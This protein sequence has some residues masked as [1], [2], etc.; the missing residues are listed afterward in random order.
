VVT[1]LRPMLRLAKLEGDAAFAYAMTDAVDGPLLQD[2]IEGSYFAF[3]RRLRDIRQSSSCECNACIL[4]PALD[5]KYVLHHG[6]VVRQ[7]I[8]SSEELVGSDVIV[9]HR[10]LKNG[11]TE[12]T[13]IGAYALYTDACLAAMALDDPSAAGM[14]RHEEAFDGV[15]DVGGWVADLTAAWSAELQR[16]RVVVEAEAALAAYEATFDAPPGLVWEYITSPALR[17]L[18]QGAV[19]AVIREAG[20][21]G[22]RGIGTVNH[23]MH[24]KG[25]VIEE[26]VDWEPVDH[27]TYRS[28]VPIPG[29]PKLLNTFQLFDLGDGRT[30]LELRFGQP[31]TKKD[32][33]VAG[34]LVTEMD[35]AIKGDMVRLASVVDDAAR[36]SAGV[37]LPS[38]PDIP[39]SRGRMVSEPITRDG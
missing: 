35:A 27:V 36:E 13:G 24:G 15:G 34:G 28:L 31:R 37:E 20:P 32:R 4:V 30:R 33:A 19:E 2:T 23:C 22:R 26:V 11:V 10:L 14:V 5:L 7:R 21:P 9:V 8:G 29:A 3:Q 38:E 39:V 25:V 1:S 18:W 12:G 6:L 16:T 17:P